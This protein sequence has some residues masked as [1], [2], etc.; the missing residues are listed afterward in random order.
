[1]AHLAAV[2]HRESGVGRKLKGALNAV[3]AH[4]GCPLSNSLCIFNK[5]I[6]ILSVTAQAIRNQCL[7]V[8]D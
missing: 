1:M 2:A 5:I 4:S 8:A 7:P 3:P 6:V